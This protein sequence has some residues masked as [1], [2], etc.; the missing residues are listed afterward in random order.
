M[1]ALV[2]AVVGIIAFYSRRKQAA[3]VNM[4]VDGRV[5]ISTN[6]AYSVPNLPSNETRRASIAAAQ[7]PTRPHRPDTAGSAAGG[8]DADTD[9]AD[10]TDR[11]GR[12]SSGTF[13]FVPGKA[14]PIDYSVG[15]DG[16]NVTNN[17]TG[18]RPQETEYDWTLN[19][20]YSTADDNAGTGGSTGA[21]DGP[22]YA[23]Y[24]GS[25]G[26]SAGGEA[27]TYACADGSG[28]P[29]YAVACHAATNPGATK[30]SRGVAVEGVQYDRLAPR[31]KKSG[32]MPAPPARK[33]R[34]TAASAARGGVASGGGGGG[35]G[36]TENHY[37]LPAPGDRR[38]RRTQSAVSTKPVLRATGS[39]PRANTAFVE[40]PR[41]LDRKQ[42][43][44][45]AGFAEDT[46]A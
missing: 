21:V 19:A 7:S 25:S 11:P 8:A 22:V 28:A 4:Q 3:N 42:A 40:S 29:D 24:A 30:S 32:G 15:A 6:P 31:G 14:V 44:V 36:A 17:S 18:S 16:S 1:L 33:I 37:D 9:A 41:G 13:T 46:E 43:S 5:T 12:S 20:M 45:Y 27:P 10:A 38:R 34:F 26:D 2:V 39:R 23:V 35:G